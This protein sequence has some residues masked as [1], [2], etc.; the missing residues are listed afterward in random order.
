MD[1]SENKVI[2][3]EIR[4]IVE[5]G[6]ALLTECNGEAFYDLF[7]DDAS[8]IMDGKLV[9]SWEGH[10]QA[11]ITFLGSLKKASYTMG[12]QKIKILNV[13]TAL[14]L[15][16]FKYELVD[17]QNTCIEGEGIQT[18]VLVRQGDGWK[19]SHSH[20]SGEYRGARS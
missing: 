17:S 8:V 3:K 15:G 6:Y 13:E 4:Q 19:V 7:T 2:L 5:T 10:Q 20:V 18:W 1:K 9:P 12:E 14:A 11:G 16:N